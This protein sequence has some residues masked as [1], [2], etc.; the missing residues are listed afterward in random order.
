MVGAYSMDGNLFDFEGHVQTEAKAS[1]MVT[2]WKSALLRPFDGLF[3]KDGAGAELPI[4]VHG[5]K[6][7]VSFGLHDHHLTPDEMAAQLRQNAPPPRAKK[8]PDAPH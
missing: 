1:Q 8:R 5:T 3:A 6:G 4:A 2:G 7:D